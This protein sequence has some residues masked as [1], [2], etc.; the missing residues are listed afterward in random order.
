M[1]T[2]NWYEI[3][4]EILIRKGIPMQRKDILIYLPK[5]QEQTNVTLDDMHLGMTLNQLVTSKK[6]CVHK[7]DG[8]PGF[9]YIPSWED[10][11]THELLPQFRFDP[12]TKKP[13]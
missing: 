2:K 13:I 11:L 1:V 12:Y 7:V 6:L 5:Y 10:K 9:Y 4:V 3:I 8:M